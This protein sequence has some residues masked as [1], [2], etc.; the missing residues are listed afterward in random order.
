M[1]SP[2][3]ANV[4]HIVAYIDPG[5]LNIAVGLLISGV[6]GGLFVVKVLWARIKGFFGNLASKVKR[7]DN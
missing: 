5:T 7:N 2:F 1:I 4:P 3:T 6:L